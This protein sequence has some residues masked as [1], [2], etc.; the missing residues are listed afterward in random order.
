MDDPD[1]GHVS[2]E[3]IN[4]EMILATDALIKSRY[5][6]R[7]IPLGELRQLADQ[8]NQ[9]LRDMVTQHDPTKT[10]RIRN[11]HAYVEEGPGDAWHL[12]MTA[13]VAREDWDRWQNEL[14][15]AGVPGGM[16]IGLTQ[17]ITDPDEPRGL[18]AGDAADFEDAELIQLAEMFSKSDIA[19]ARLY[20]FSADPEVI[21]LITDIAIGATGSLAA[22]AVIAAGKKLITALRTKESELGR[23]AA[24]DVR[25]RREPGG[26]VEFEGRFWASDE[27][28]AI[29]ALTRAIAELKE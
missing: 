9:N 20:Q 8:M 13:D 10:M 19:V 11:A 16:S 5:G 21:R 2:D 23:P 12:K 26:A 3:W 28:T 29:D 15:Q 1:G 17:P 18:L 22:A 25:L 14:K 6:E 27:Q 24:W 4:A 7:S